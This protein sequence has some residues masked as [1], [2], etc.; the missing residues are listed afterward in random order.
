MCQTENRKENLLNH[1]GYTT[2]TGLTIYELIEGFDRQFSADAYKAITGSQTDIKQAWINEMLTYG[3]GLWGTGYGIEYETSDIHYSTVAPRGN[4]GEQVHVQLTKAVF[5]YIL[6]NEDGEKER[7][8]M[9]LNGG[10]ASTDME[11]AFNGALTNVMTH[12]SKRLLGQLS[13]FKGRRSHLTPQEEKPKK[14]QDDKKEQEPKKEKK[15][16]ST[17]KNMEISD[18]IDAQSFMRYMAVKGITKAQYEPM[19]SSMQGNRISYAQKAT[20]IIKELTGE[21]IEL[22]SN[23]NIPK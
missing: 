13:V 14:S 23:F 16:N 10:N 19:L 11:H 20:E 9:H 8:E 17:A 6:V 18:V 21:I 22:K 15:K 3:F 2:L 12:A 5:W 4:Q 7:H 1:A